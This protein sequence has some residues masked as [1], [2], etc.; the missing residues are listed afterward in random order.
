MKYRCI[1]T[2]MQGPIKGHFYDVTYIE[3]ERRYYFIVGDIKFNVN[4]YQ[5]GNYFKKVF[6]YGK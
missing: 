5:F 4:Y 1:K 2:P 6:N 3:E